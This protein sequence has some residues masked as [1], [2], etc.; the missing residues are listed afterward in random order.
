MENGSHILTLK[1]GFHLWS[2]T[3]NS[4]GKTKVIAVH[5]GPGDNHESFETLPAALLEN[6][7]SY[8][9]QLG[10]WYSDQP[11]FSDLALAEKYLNI[12]YFVDELEAVRQ[13][14]GY[15]KFVLLGY[16]WG[17]MIA[18][19]YALKYPKR[20][21]KLI[22]VGMSDRDRDF[23][24]R[25][26]DEVSKVLSADEAA[27][28]FKEANAGDLNDPLF[29]QYM[30]RFY[31]D[32]YG[33]FSKSSTTHAVSTT[34]MQ[35]ADYMMGRNP[36]QTVGMMAGWDISD[37]ID[38]INTPTQFMIGDQDM[39]PIARIQ[40]IIRHMQNAKLVVVPQATHVVIRDNPE[41]FFQQLNNFLNN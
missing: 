27:Y 36:F 24:D 8:Y 35:V 16:S 5:G 30:A 13:Q 1:N 9:D 17:G 21:N 32:Y 28:V 40:K 20:L 7:I 6:E 33:R 41:Y 37:R 23:T 4:G 18:L 15:E 25:M 22:I 10:S 14:L 11:D 12:A 38:Q 26:K 3:E 39:I 29:N 31:E 2:H 19:E 34:N